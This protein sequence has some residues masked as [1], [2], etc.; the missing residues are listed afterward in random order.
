MLM[1]SFYVIRGGCCGY[2]KPIIGIKLIRNAFVPYELCFRFLE[3]EVQR[4]EEITSWA[5]YDE[6]N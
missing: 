4:I 2:F 3:E 1:C 6:M 5:V